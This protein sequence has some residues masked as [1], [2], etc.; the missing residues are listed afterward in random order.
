[1]E[2]VE[3]RMPP[4][5]RR[6][7][8]AVPAGAALAVLLPALGAGFV[9]DDVPQILGN[10][11]LRDL[12]R[13]PELW[14]SG[15]WAGAGSGSSW[16]RPLMTT[17]FALEHALFGFSAP[18][19]HAVQLGCYAAVVTLGVLLVR[20]VQGDGTTAVLAGL[21]FAT[22]P[23]GVEP[24]VWISARCELLAA[25]GG[26]AAMGLHARALASDD[27]RRARRL[28]L[29]AA[30]CLGLALFG[31]ENAVG[32]VPALV[33]LDAVAGASLAPAALLRRHA[34]FLAACG[35]YAALRTAAL[36]SVSGGLGGTVALGD[37]LGAWGQGLLRCLWPRALTISP[38]APGPTHVALGAA[39]VLAAIAAGLAG[40]RR[41]GPWLVPLVLGGAQL[42][43][44]AVAA[45]RVGELADRYLLLPCLALAW[46]VAAALRRALPAPA[47]T[48]LVLALAVALGAA[49]RGHVAVFHDD[50]TLWTDA[51]SKNPASLRAAV[52]LA[53]GA[54]GRDDPRTAEVWLAR[55]A[56]LDPD[57]RQ[58]LL[59]RAVA[60]DRLGR[61]EEARRLLERLVAR[62]AG[63]AAAQLALGHL[64]L[65]R[66][67]ADEAARRYRAVLGLRPG[68]AEAWAGLGVAEHDRGDRDAARDA[69]ARAL[70]LD[71]NV[72]NAA[73]LRRLLRELGGAAPEGGS[74]VD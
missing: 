10:P 17:S 58:V 5:R 29:A 49:A 4:G 41:R 52:N 56:A 70:A 26:L 34:V 63:D 40:L 45:V 64:A 20:R 16:Y 53:A 12:A 46:G 39:T 14:T 32:F 31:K 27:A 33:A 19:M 8:L 9:H 43:I 22:H 50:Q 65:D 59:N 51:W 18:A 1:M 7:L 73:S 28:D 21:L 68:A 69:L 13:I 54:L 25:G 44:A 35:A 23:L 62:D 57:D 55:A 11:L 36:G 74:R 66:R 38:P 60:A 67:D 72:A 30:A 71:P 2:P 42:A 24:A 48:A 47:A 37:W 3:A 61:P 15:V 6:A